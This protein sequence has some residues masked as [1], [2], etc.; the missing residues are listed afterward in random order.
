MAYKLRSHCPGSSAD[1]QIVYRMIADVNS[2]TQLQSI[3]LKMSAY[4]SYE[5][6]FTSKK[7]LTFP[8]MFSKAFFTRHSVCF[9]YHVNIEGFF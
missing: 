4:Y 8:S 6:V 3:V 2:T 1:S 7:L 9:I 5:D